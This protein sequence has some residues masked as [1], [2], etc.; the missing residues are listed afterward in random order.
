MSTENDFLILGPVGGR[1]VFDGEED[2]ADIDVQSSARDISANWNEFEDPESDVIGVTW[3]AGTAPRRCD[4]V[5]RAQIEPSETSVH[6]APGEDL[7]SGQRYY[8]TVQA[9]NGAGLVTTLTSDG[10]T[11][12]TTPPMSGKVIDGNAVDVD[13]FFGEDDVAARWFNFTD[14]ESGIQSYEVAICGM[15]NTNC[16]QPFVSVG[17]ATNVTISGTY[18][19]RKTFS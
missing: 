2:G 3:C 5:G 19:Q 11:I 1:A 16:P 7:I 17:L 15:R 10:V 4:L 14:R 12:D 9:T 6:Q 13:Y 18:E 8:V